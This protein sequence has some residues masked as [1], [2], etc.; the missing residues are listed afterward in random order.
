MNFLNQDKNQDKYFILWINDNKKLPELQYISIKSMLLSG[1]D[2]L[3]YITYNELDNILE[4][5][6]MKDGN[7]ILNENKIFKYRE[8][9]EKI[10]TLVLQIGSD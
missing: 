10:L 6:N 2:L 4:G 5:V 3:Y 1:H 9:Q 7:T 8:E